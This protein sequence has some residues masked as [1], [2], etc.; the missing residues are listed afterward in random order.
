VPEGEV[1][2]KALNTVCRTL[3]TKF[4]AV[5]HPASTSPAGSKAALAT[6]ALATSAL[7]TSALATSAL[8]TSALATSG[9]A[10][11]ALATSALSTAADER[12][13][14]GSARST[15]VTNKGSTAEGKTMRSACLQSWAPRILRAARAP[16]VFSLLAQAARRYATGGSL[17]GRGSAWSRVS[18]VAPVVG[19]LLGHALDL[20]LGETYVHGA[21]NRDEG[22]RCRRAGHRGD[23]VGGKYL[24]Q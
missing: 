12:P 2:C 9:L 11:S 1:S 23:T 17:A 13:R 10:T 8:A 19:H 7:A 24:H 16:G 3:W 21:A 6:P 15:S 4:E 18:P 20:Y 5:E 22:S 14:G